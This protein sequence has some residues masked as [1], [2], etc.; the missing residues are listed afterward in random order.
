MKMDAAS[1]SETG[2]GTGTGSPDEPCCTAVGHDL[3]EARIERDVSLLDA[4]G[5][6]TRYTVLR[7]IAGADG[8][9]CACDLAPELDVDQSTASRALKA[10]FEAGLL[11]RRKDGRWRY[12]STTEQAERLLSAL[13]SLGGE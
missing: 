8:P 5:T 13:D 7:L 11:D 1:K 9:V 6:G 3:S 4:M 2:D 12:Y 10:L